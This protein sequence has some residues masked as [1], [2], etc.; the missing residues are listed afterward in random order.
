MASEDDYRQREFAGEHN[1]KP[2]QEL[3]CGVEEMPDW[4]R[5]EFLQT[6]FNLILALARAGSK[7]KSG[8]PL[9]SGAMG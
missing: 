6:K 5:R 8:Q 9:L 1:L 2:L 3:N 4:E 7:G